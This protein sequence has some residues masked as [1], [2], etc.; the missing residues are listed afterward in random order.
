MMI[1]RMTYPSEVGDMIRVVITPTGVYRDDDGDWTVTFKVQGPGGEEEIT[2]SM[3]EALALDVET[4]EP[5]SL[6]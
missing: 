3:D 4:K 6:N 2:L 1:S 5:I